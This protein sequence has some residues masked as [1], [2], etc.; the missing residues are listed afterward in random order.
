M[1]RRN[2]SRIPGV[3]R[4][5]STS[6]TKSVQLEYILPETAERDAQVAASQAFSRAK[7]RSS[8]DAILWPP[9]RSGDFNRPTPEKHKNEAPVHREQS[10]RFIRPRSSQLACGY[11]PIEDQTPTRKP[12]T[13]KLKVAGNGTESRPGS[14]ASAAGM[15]SA[16]KGAAGDYI[17]A[18]ITGEEYYTPEDN[19]AS[20]PSSY[21]RIRKSRSMFTSSERSRISGYQTDSQVST[22]VSNASIP[23]ADENI[24][25]AGLKAPKSM[26]FL[27]GRQDQTL[28]FSDDDGGIPI[29]SPTKDLVRST[30]NRGNFLKSQSSLLFRPKQSNP[31]KTF[32]KSMRD[33]SDSTISTTGKV[34]KEGSLRSK[35]RKVSQ[36]FKHKLKNFFALGKGDGDED[37]FPPQQ[38]EARKYH[39]ADLESQEYD[40]NEDIQLE[41]PTDECALSRVTSGVPYLHAVPSCQQLRSRQGS[42]ESLRS[43][44]K[45]SDERS[46]VT[47]WTNSDTNTL[48]TMGSN[49]GEWERQRLS[50]IK[51]N[52]MHISSSSAIKPTLSNPFS[53]LNNS[54]IPL[55]PPVPPR[56]GTVDSQRIYSALMKRLN[57]TEQQN[58]ELRRQ[59]SA[60][61]LKN[62]GVAPLSGSSSR[63]CEDPGLSTPT[64][65]RQVIP[66]S[67][68][69]SA[70]ARTVERKYTA[71]VDQLG[72]EKAP[73]ECES[74]RN[75]YGM[76]TSISTQGVN[77][78][79]SPIPH[80]EES[81]PLK[82]TL[83]SRSSAFFASPTCHLFRTQS[84]YRRVLQ[85]KMESAT[86]DQQP[87]SP[88][89][90]P[91]MCSLSNLPLRCQSTCE[92]E[93][94]QK[95][96]YAES[97]YSCNTDD[98]TSEINNTLSLVD[99]FPKPPSAH[100]N[101]TIFV[102]PP[103]YRP[104]PPI[105]SQRRMA[106]SAS[107]VE[108]KTW[109]SANVS[110]LEETSTQ[111]KIDNFEYSLPSARS[112]SHVRENA[113]IDDDDDDEEDLEP[114]EAYRPTRPGSALA[115]I[116]HDSDTSSESSRPISAE[117]LPQEVSVNGDDRLGPPPLPPK[118][119][120][121]SVPSASSMR[122]TQEASDTGTMTTDDG[123]FDSIRKKSLRRMPSFSTFPGN[124]PRGGRSATAK[125]VRRQ[126]RSKE[127]NLL[128]AS[129]GLANAVE[130]QFGKLGEPTGSKLRS[131]VTT[132][133]K[134]ENISP[135]AADTQDPYGIDGAGV[136]G[137]NGD[138]NLQAI[139]S[140]R[141]VDLF[142][143][144]RRRRM[145]SS[146]ED[147][148]VF[149]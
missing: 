20:E 148:R 10:V 112:S 38:I 126:P 62:F 40:P 12:G 65:I 78:Q 132:N 72:N 130:Q 128:G 8:T 133:T 29:M 123:V 101:A 88:D 54:I 33:T 138:P 86:H 41:V 58:Q 92:S 3:D 9:P 100:G 81:Q 1:H 4:R 11:S 105:V 59:K 115:L 144:S 57:E 26:S 21:R 19:V 27:R 56:P 13:M 131:S 35:A 77:N 134:T 75:R 36:N 23:K 80:I 135:N 53:L 70:S 140:K 149:L 98:Q 22:T 67:A 139:G 111:P 116:E 89:F 5:K 69:D 114:M 24:P 124:Q 51:E 39:N 118:S 76:A 142:L 74:N 18:L 34:S 84:P 60:D 129:P 109:L 121:R 136:L 50:V 64:T 93:I 37:A 2:S 125:L 85:D 42:V 15:V 47:S 141:I 82:R 97:V 49:R 102:D 46:R 55:P 61:S 71:Q 122:S 31:D 45:A 113:Q 68:S 44:R 147:G 30:N 48:N 110:K 99:N 7:E 32:R 120:L 95:M 83:S 25:P 91:W 137:P 119:V 107:S 145:A 94:D 87:K 28:Q 79:D 43:E 96:Y 90:N 146:S 108:W 63:S 103:T 6:S 117:I 66:D 14:S 104:N 106:S 127:S 16:A 73:A 143:N 17:N 52:G